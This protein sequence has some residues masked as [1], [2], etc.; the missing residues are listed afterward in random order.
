[1]YVV[2]NKTNKTIL[3]AD[4]RLE[5]KPRAVIDLELVASRS[6]IDCSHDLKKAFRNKWL[7]LGKHS[8]IKTNAVPSEPESAHKHTHEVKVI[9]KER[10][11]NEQR[12]AELVRSVVQEEVRQNSSTSSG[13]EATNVRK[14][15]AD[16]LNALQQSIREQINSIRVPA[17]ENDEEMLIDPKQFAEMSQKS[18][19]KL[20]Q[21][22]ETTESRKL[23]KKY[24]IKSN[25][26]LR[27]LADE[28]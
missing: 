20:S 5:I 12:M 23:G 8:V 14:A 24:K 27:D 7:L 1:M 6:S 22:I 15:V 9:E 11:F 10:D 25:K 4:L 2:H 28:L 21:D 13:E 3:I 18:I 26:N 19:D 16:G 17:A